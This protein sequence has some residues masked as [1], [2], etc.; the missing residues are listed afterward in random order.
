MLNLRPDSKLSSKGKGSVQ[1]IYLTRTHY[2]SFKK[3][4]KKEK[5]GLLSSFPILNALL[6]SVFIWPFILSHLFLEVEKQGS[7]PIISRTNSDRLALKLPVLAHCSHIHWVINILAQV[8]MCHHYWRQHNSLNYHPNILW[9][10]KFFSICCKW[11]Y[12]TSLLSVFCV[13]NDVHF[14]RT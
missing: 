8:K 10:L 9:V 14:S 4:K 7:D 1:S 5:L 13:N 3:G 12:T 6:V 2:S 11:W